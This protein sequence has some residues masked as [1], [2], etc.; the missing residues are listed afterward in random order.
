MTNHKQTESASAA[1]EAR[2]IGFTYLDGT[3][4]VRRFVS[5]NPRHVNE[6]ASA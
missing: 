3:E 6:G 1:I 2:D 5:H 4:A